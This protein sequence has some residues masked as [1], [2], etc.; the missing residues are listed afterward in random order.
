MRRSPEH[1][2]VLDGRTLCLGCLYRVARATGK[3]RFRMVC[4]L[5]GDRLTQ[6]DLACCFWP[7]QPFPEDDDEGGAA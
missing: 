2:Q 1:R 6:N 3:G 5:H 7:G 4:Q